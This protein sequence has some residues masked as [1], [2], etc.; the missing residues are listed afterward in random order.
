MKEMYNIDNQKDSICYFKR[1]D[2]QGYFKRANLVKLLYNR[3]HRM[4]SVRQ[5]WYPGTKQ[6]RLMMP[7]R[8][9]P[10]CYN[11]MGPCFNEC[12][13]GGYSVAGKYFRNRTYHPEKHSIYLK[14]EEPGIDYR[15]GIA[16]NCKL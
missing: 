4:V 8:S 16:A 6:A 5:N 3:F 15:K 1:E 11:C 9:A 12:S 10:Q 13:E 2:G 14:T 7:D